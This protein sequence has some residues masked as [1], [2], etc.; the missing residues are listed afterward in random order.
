MKI[1]LCFSS[2]FKILIIS[3]MISWGT[4][5]AASLKDTLTQI[6]TGPY[7][8]VACQTAIESLIGGVKGLGVA[9]LSNLSFDDD[10]VSG[11]LKM[12]IGGTWRLYLFGADCSKE[13]Y[14]FLK[15][16]KDLKFSDMISS[17]SVLK[18]LDR[19]G[20]NNQAFIISNT[21]GSIS[22]EDAPDKVSKAITAATD[23]DDKAEIEIKSGLTILG[24]MDLSKSSYTNS[25]L[26]FMGFK[27]FKSKKIAVDAQLG[28]EMLESIIKGSKAKAD[29]TITGTMP[30]VTLTLPGKHKLPTASLTFKADV[31]SDSKEFE[32]TIEAKHTWKKA[33][34]IPGLDL[35]NVVIDIKAGHETAAELDAETKLG[36]QKL[37]VTM[38]VEK[39]D[40]NTEIAVKLTEPGD[41]TFKIGT[42]LRLS[43]VPGINDIGFKELEVSSAGF[44][45]RIIW[46]SKELDAAVVTL[47]HGNKPVLMFKTET[48][49]LKEISSAIGKTPLGKIEIPGMI[50]TLAE[51]DPGSINMDD[52]P[53]VASLVL[54]DLDEKSDGNL[55]LHK[56][57]GILGVLDTDDL[58]NSGKAL[59][60]SGE[61]VLGGTLGGIFGGD[62]EVDLYAQFPTF[63]SK[64]M[65][66]FLKA[67]KDVTPVLKLAFKEDN[68]LEADIGVGLMTHL[69]VGKQIIELDTAI[70]A[71]IATSGV[72]LDISGSLDKW[73]D[74]FS[75]KGFEIDDVAV[76]IGVDVDGSVSAGFQG[77][78]NLKDGKTEF[79]I[80]ALMTPDPE[81]LG[82]PKEVV[83]KLSA[84]HISLQG[85]MDLAD[86]FIGATGKNSLAKAA[87]GKGLFD[88]LQFDKLPLIE[89]VKY[90][91]DDG[92]MEEVEIYM[93]T[94]GATDPA[95]DIDGMGLGL[96]GRMKV[97]GK[98][99]AQAKL[100]LNEDGFS[101]DG[102]ILIKKIGLL[103]IKNAE[104]DAAASVDD[105]PHLHLNAD[106]K[107]LGV[108]E[109]IIIE[110][111]KEK[112]GFEETSK[113]GQVFSSKIAAWATVKNKKD[114]DFD[115]ALEFQGDLLDAV[116]AGIEDGLNDLMGDYDKDVKKAQAKLE[117]AKKAVN[118][119]EK[120]VDAAIKMAEKTII[121]GEK[122]ITA[123]INK[124]NG[125]QKTIN[126]KKDAV[127]DQ[128]KALHKLHWYQVGKAIKYSAE[129]AVLEI[130]LGELYA[131]KETAKAA[132]EVVK[133]ATDLTPALFQEGVQAANSAFE[134]AKGAIKA[135]EIAVEESEYIFKGLKALIDAYRKN[136][137]FTEAKFDGSL[138]ALLGKKDITMVAKFTA[139]GAD[140]DADLSFSPAKPENL[141]K[142]I[143]KMT[144]KLAD[145]A[146]DG[147]KHAFFGGGSTHSNSQSQAVADWVSKNN[148]T[149]DSAGFGGASWS[150]HGP[151]NKDIPM[152]GLVF[153]NAG[154]KKCMKLSNNK[155]VIDPQKHCNDAKDAHLFRF[156]PDGDLISVASGDKSSLCLEAKG[157]ENGTSVSLEKCNGEHFQKWTQVSNQVLSASGLCL[158]IDKKNKTIVNDCVTTDKKQSWNTTPIA[159][160]DALSKMPQTNMYGV[161]FR[162]TK[163]KTCIDGADKI[164]LSYA[165]DGE[166]YQTFNLNSSGQMMTQNQCIHANGKKNGSILYLD[167]CDGKE[168]ALEWIGQRMRLKNG[169]LCLNRSKNL[170]PVDIT[171]VTLGDCKSTS[172]V[173][174][175]E[176]TNIDSKGRILPAYDMVRLKSNNKCIEVRT[177]LQV[178]GLPIPQ[179]VL[180]NCNGD[181]NQNLSFRWN[182]EIRSLGQCLSATNKK[183]AKLELKDCFV[184]PSA[185]AITADMFKNPGK[186]RQNIN[187][188]RWKIQKDG[189]IK[190]HGTKLCISADPKGRHML[191]TAQLVKGIMKIQLPKTGKPGTLG[192]LLVLDSCKSKNKIQTWV[193][194]NKLPSGKK[195][196]G[197]QTISHKIGK[198]KRCLSASGNDTVRKL[199]S[200]ECAKN[201]TDQNF[202][203][204]DY[205]EI[206]QMGR[207]LSTN[208]SSKPSSEGY[209]LDFE[210][211]SDSNLQKWVH[212]KSGLISQT[213]KKSKE[214]CILDGPTF[215]LGLPSLSF[216]SKEMK[217]AMEKMGSFAI[218]GSQKCSVNNDKSNKSLQW[219]I[220]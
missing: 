201:D 53:D 45:G 121:N 162:D 91:N 144:K 124:V 220:P 120:S 109:S 134:V 26:S 151:G 108:E 146:V 102:K 17:I 61:L 112:V 117:K 88:T 183:G 99:L 125:L 206:R 153:T 211:C 127:D 116:L 34:G 29:F 68:G 195:F 196:A 189:S 193:I 67:A 55:E 92:D 93:A 60:V 111:S 13:I 215:S 51:H 157:I 104:L 5:Q 143:G 188:Q 84:N 11:D 191:Q 4:L 39:A 139:F 3:S 57:V 166:D 213:D 48:F 36:R 199:I 216:M 59:G 150:G 186:N 132:L 86:V 83:F 96:E 171:A 164:L 76:S 169:K 182:G 98:D 194:D 89:F 82:M 38:S 75:L 94:P 14:A 179:I 27:N 15:P 187:H 163:T 149:K 1:S 19:L 81:A 205:G 28:S 185:F 217:K 72:G 100:E 54:A 203:V 212:Q 142:S 210:E 107:L 12:P 158:A 176:P 50:F 79:E 6:D 184:R 180:W 73:D 113:F 209:K 202:V 140:V 198:K 118:E 77:T 37:D 197:Y 31:H 148:T 133:A 40:K 156:S 174:E 105:V 204:T 41:K 69:K 23:G 219:D 78:V 200:R 114:P 71:V 24:V 177:K 2:I 178:D 175:E 167:K 214:L 136:F 20:L 33:L 30:S 159:D 66:K 64:K 103:K 207:C 154:D 147:I 74:A 47:G 135:S 70:T 128:K 190:K 131:A 161:A 155:L 65:P 165:C 122:K 170:G 80:E 21:E 56:G 22:A 52:I 43:K 18:E 97:A 137:H 208:Y 145:E 160:L 101:V 123:A 172:S 110:F 138:Q 62:P 42:L 90:K 10:V 85:L 58:G 192:S 35:S 141:T 173:W 16:G 44:S 119:K 87:R 126:K 9:E 181:Y 25:A 95:L 115:I 49:S 218:V 32:M 8:D 106:A 46:K 130:N 63:S 7:A 152:K 129:I 168:L